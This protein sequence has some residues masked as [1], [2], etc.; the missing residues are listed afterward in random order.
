MAYRETPR[1]RARR[2]AA[3]QSILSAAEALVS[4][5]GFR[6]A[7]IAQV[8]ERAG[9]AVGT[10]YRY[11]QSKGELFSEV[12][13]VATQ[14]EVDRVEQ[15]LQR[16]GTASEQ[17]ETALRLFA[18]RALRGPTMAWALIAEPVDPQVDAERL[19]YRRTYAELFE[20]TLRAGMESGEFRQQDA[21]LSSAAIVGAIAE[22]LV[23]PLSPTN[24]EKTV[25]HDEQI[26]AITQFCL[27]AVKEGGDRT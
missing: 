22:A 23:G 12:F 20:R 13:R 25:D 11:F 15:A 19:R 2:Q 5:G 8:A 21:A 17:L 27:M 10:V 18:S 3:R 14:R 24:R 9:I 6:D 26:S 1:S 16:E 7:G 4:Q